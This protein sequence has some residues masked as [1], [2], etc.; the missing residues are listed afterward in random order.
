MAGK[1]ITVD[2][3]DTL[4]ALQRLYAAAGDLLPVFK[5]IG[6]YETQVTKQRFIS[7]TD[8]DGVAWQDLNTLYATTKKGPGKLRGETRR[9]SQ[10]IYQAANDNVE[11]GSDVIYARIHNEGGVIRPKNASALVFSMGGQTFKVKSVTMPQRRFLGFSDAD[12]VEI[13]SIIQDH[14]QDAINGR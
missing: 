1:S 14:F 13:Q 11:I 6:E 7:E 9:L 8:P 12:Q 10:I 5:N 3:A 2:D 4:A